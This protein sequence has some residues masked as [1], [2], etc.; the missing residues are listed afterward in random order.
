MKRVNEETGRKKRPAK[1][2]EYEDT[3]DVEAGEE[4]GAIERSELEKDEQ[5]EEA[6]VRPCWQSVQSTR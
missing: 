4:E 6:R 3:E 5:E 2:A 1:Q